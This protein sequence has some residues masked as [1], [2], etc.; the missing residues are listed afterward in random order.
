MGD[1]RVGLVVQRYPIELSL[2]YIGDFVVL[3]SN[4]AWGGGIQ[5]VVEPVRWIGL[6]NLNFFRITEKEKFLS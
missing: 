6:R 5:H 4:T 3:P 2:V 1:F